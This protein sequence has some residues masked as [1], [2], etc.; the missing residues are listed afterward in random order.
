MTEYWN[1]RSYDPKGNRFS[2]PTLNVWNYLNVLNDLNAS[3]GFYA[4]SPVPS[5]TPSMRFKF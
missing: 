4:G 1:T 5:G 3:Q 2:A